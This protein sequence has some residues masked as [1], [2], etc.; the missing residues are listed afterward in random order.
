MATDGACL[1][2]SVGKFYTFSSIV[3]FTFYHFTFNNRM[4]DKNSF[5]KLDP[6]E[7]KLKEL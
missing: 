3:H 7:N 6:V 5:I 2:R 1:F 4:L